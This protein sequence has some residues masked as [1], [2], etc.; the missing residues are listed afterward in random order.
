MLH[1]KPSKGLLSSYSTDLN[2]N[3]TLYYLLLGA[4]PE[5]RGT[6][7]SCTINGTTI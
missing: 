3:S 7:V 6:Q 4:V 2:R 5:P 1:Q